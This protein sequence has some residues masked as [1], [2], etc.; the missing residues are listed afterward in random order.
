[1]VKEEAK[2]LNYS[3]GLPSMMI[4]RVTHENENI[5]EYTKGIARGDRFKY[6]VVLEK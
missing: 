1:M 4:E 3:A 2:L 6:H 5:I